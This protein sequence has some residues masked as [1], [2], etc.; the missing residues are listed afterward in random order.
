M[1]WCVHAVHDIE[2]CQKPN[3]LHY[4]WI[5]AQFTDSHGTLT[6]HLILP[7]ANSAK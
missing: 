4:P 3:E 2:A 1:A 7:S 6:Q 5:A